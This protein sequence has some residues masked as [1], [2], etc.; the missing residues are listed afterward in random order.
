MADFP[1]DVRPFGRHLLFYVYDTLCAAV[2]FDPECQVE[3]SCAHLAVK[4]GEV[5]VPDGDLGP[6]LP[7]L[8]L[9]ELRSM[10]VRQAMAEAQGNKRRASVLLGVH[11]QSVLNWVP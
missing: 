9:K 1:V 2:C 10:A 5:C 11:Y 3:W 4:H 6:R 7:T 8:N